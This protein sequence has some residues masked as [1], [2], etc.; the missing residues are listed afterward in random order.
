MAQ[1]PSL[2]GLLIGLVLV[3]LFAGI[4]GLFIGKLGQNYEITQIDNASLTSYNKIKNLSDQSNEIR[5]N[6][7]NVNPGESGIADVLGGLF[8]N[9]YKVLI[10][11]PKSINFIFTMSTQAILDLNL[12]DG[13][14]LLSDALLTILSL[15]IFVGIILSI[16]LKRDGL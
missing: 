12:G 4:F 6:T 3:S 16:L 13:G 14:I 7:L 2:T 9:S 1:N 8:F 11:I 5:E 10:S 15:M